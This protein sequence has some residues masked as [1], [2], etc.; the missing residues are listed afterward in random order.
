MRKV[1]LTKKGI[2]IKRV[3]PE[4][5]YRR[6]TARSLGPHANISQPHV[7]MDD[8][9]TSI[10]GLF[11]RAGSKHPEP[12]RRIRRKFRKFVRNWLKKNLTPLP[13]DC[14][15][16]F[17]TWLDKCPYP[18][19]RK[20]ELW[21]KYGAVTNEDDKRWKIIKAFIKDE[22]YPA[23]KHA[24]CIFSRTDEFKCFVGPY[25]RAIEEEV[26]KLPQFIKHVPVKAR[27]EY[28]KEY[29]KGEGLV[30][31]TD[32]SAFESQ[33][34]RDLMT[35]CEMQLYVYMTQYLPGF[36]QFMKHFDTIRASAQHIVF[37]YF[38]AE[39]PT[40][41]MSG[42]MCTSL[43]NGF[44]NLMFASFL[45]SERG[46]TDLKIVVEGDDGLMKTNAVLT[47]EDFAELGLTIKIEKHDRMETASFCGIIFD[48][49]EL[50]TLTNPL[51][52]LADFGWAPARYV[53][54]NKH[55]L[56]LLLRAKSLSL[57]HSY[58]GCPIISSL[59][60][61]G[62]RVTRHVRDD[63]L[64]RHIREAGGYNQWE[65]EQMLS[66]LVEIE[67]PQYR[68]ERKVVLVPPGWRSRLLI[69]ELYHIEPEIQLYIEE[70]FKNKNDMS[71]INIPI[72]YD[73][74]P[75]S[76]IHY[77][78]NFTRKVHIEDVNTQY[79]DGDGQDHRDRLLQMCT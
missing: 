59:A 47:A 30:Y 77:H 25:F 26:Y 42:E 28:I 6:A 43:G 78:E 75:N 8:I 12:N 58:P 67:T 7:D 72:L 24:R 49:E 61:Y 57:A 33:F 9:L 52:V 62:L 14:D 34:T 46:D 18:A 51:E 2:K 1:N 64:R 23:Y 41:R 45:A 35:D 74:V 48:S 17:K 69:D 70:Y 73:L 22:R 13:A 10:S 44:S 3:R 63:A 19:W 11:H 5:E 37:K 31:A 21:A 20:E 39:L 36:N 27:P 79:F 38:D 40:C 55:K 76:W 4:R 32:Y 68:D 54:S 60:E 71:E 56:A 65:R 29:L 50:Q 15:V 66:S 16:S 53:H